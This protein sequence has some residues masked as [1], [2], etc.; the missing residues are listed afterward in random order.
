MPST[1]RDDYTR[2][3]RQARPR[4]PG[5]STASGPR[6]SP[7]PWAEAEEETSSN[8]L[9]KVLNRLAEHAFD[10][11]GRK[12]VDDRPGTDC[13][14]LRLLRTHESRALTVR[15]R[16]D[17]QVEGVRRDLPPALLLPRDSRPSTEQVNATR[18]R[19]SVS[20]LQ[21]RRAPLRLPCRAGI[22]HDRAAARDALARR[23]ENASL[24]PV[25]QELKGSVSVGLDELELREVAAA[26]AVPL[27][28]VTVLDLVVPVQGGAP[29]PDDGVA[30]RPSV[31]LDRQE[32]VH[33]AL[34]RDQGPRDI[35]VRRDLADAGREMERLAAR[36]VVIVLRV[37][38]AERVELAHGIERIQ[39][40]DEDAR[41]HVPVV[42]GVGLPVGAEDGAEGVAGRRRPGEDV[43]RVAG[44]E[45]RLKRCALSAEPRGDVRLPVA[46]RDR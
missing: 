1:S 10:D 24:D 3:S 16:V 40:A 29:G 30:E 4:L 32:R 34:Q 13:K 33:R 44:V 12:A 39:L 23:R 26:L 6:S 7:L 19:S 14:V 37:T 15:Y 20:L 38:A 8:H 36:C 22:R 45:H 21:Q 35:A 31:A 18:R 27:D 43:G 2:E 25:D 9:H 46:K 5:V 28:V 17:E 41:R 11:Q 42:V